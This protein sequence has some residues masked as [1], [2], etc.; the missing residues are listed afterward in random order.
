MVQAVL[1]SFIENN[2]R[3][4]TGDDME[5]ATAFIDGQIAN[6]EKELRDAETKRAAF[7]TRYVD[8][9]PGDGG[10]NRLEQAR[11]Q[12]IAL[13]GQ[14]VDAHGR[15][16]LLAKELSTTPPLVT[17]ESLGGGGGGD[18]PL[19][20]AEARLRDLQHIYTDAYPEVQSQKRLVETLRANPAPS[21]GGST[22]RPLGAEPCLRAAQA[23]PGGD[24]R[25]DREPA[26]PSG[27][28]YSPTGSVSTASR[29]GRRAWRRSTST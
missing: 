22:G 26:A 8:L 11:Q 25:P 9:L 17:T 27:R 1:A 5:R 3:A 21:S 19:Q 12:V 18:R 6:Y 28:R 4:T 15:R 13:T 16:V 10:T 7:R 2:R 20:A 23:A 24:G 14:L 29:A